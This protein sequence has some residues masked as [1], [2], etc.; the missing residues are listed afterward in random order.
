MTGYVSIAAILSILQI[1]VVTASVA[2]ENADADTDTVLR[3]AVTAEVTVI[4]TSIS[5]IIPSSFRILGTTT[6][7][8]TSEVLTP[9]TSLAVDK[10]AK[11]DQ[12]GRQV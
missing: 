10:V 2:L 9:T 7:P 12:L 6:I 3:E 8:T 11:R 5:E 4:F 1:N